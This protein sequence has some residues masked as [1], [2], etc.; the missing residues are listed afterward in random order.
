[1][2]SSFEEHKYFSLLLNLHFEFNALLSLN[3]ERIFSHSSSQGSF[4][5]F[6]VV[7]F[8]DEK[9]T[10]RLDFPLLWQSIMQYTPC[11]CL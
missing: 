6:I 9:S 5:A 11:V 2:Q 8:D 7:V 10:E 4:A 3:R 1:M